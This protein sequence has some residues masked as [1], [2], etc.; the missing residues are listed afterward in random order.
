MSV[1]DEF[2]KIAAVSHNDHLKKHQ[3]DGSGVIG[4]FCSYVPE[5]IISAAGLVP[6]RMR[7]VGSTKTTLGD[8]WF[9]S[10][11]CS[12]TRHVFD[13]AL[14]GKFRFLDG[15]IL[16]NACDHIRR[17]Y[18]NWRAALDH[19][20]LIHLLAVPRKKAQGAA[21]WYREEIG[22]LKSALEDHFQITITADAI[23]QAIGVNNRIRRLLAGLYAARQADNPPLTGAEA[24]AVIMAGTALPRRTFLAMLEELIRELDGRQ[25]YDGPRSRLMIQTGCLEEIAHLELIESQGGAI[26]DDSLCFGRR[27]FDSLVDESADDPLDALTD[28]YLNHLS[29]PRMSD[30]FRNRLAYTRQSVRDFR[31]DG[32]ICERLKFCDLWGGEAFILRQEARKINL[33]TLYLERELFGGGQGQTRTRVQAFMERI[34]KI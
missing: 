2:K 17:M 6:F 33:P 12:Y 3:A 23:R 18:D 1:L 24:L 11:N 32:L 16:I 4:V 9:S 7:A 19:P 13:L 21:A 14:E 34:G 5:E 30:D 15:V 10:F 22:L 26:V 31:L 20:S 29:C 28:R 8:T 25:A 27:Y